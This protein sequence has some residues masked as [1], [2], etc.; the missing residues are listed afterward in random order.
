MAIQVRIGEIDNREALA[1]LAAKARRDGIRLYRDRSG[2]YFASSTS[3]PGT[4]HYLT[5]YSCDCQGFAA[6]QRCKHHAALMSALGWLQGAPEPDPGMTITCAHTDGHYSLDAEPE[7]ME[8][9]TELLVDGDVKVRIVGDTFGLSV[10]WI[11]NGRPIDDLT[12]ATPSYLDHYEAVRYWIESLD[13][14]VP[15]HVAMQDAGIFPADEFVD[16]HP[17]AA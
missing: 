13:T 17:L 7:W 5:G 16:A 10:H 1:R 4:L 12:G 3:T 8:P 15:A 14:R 9:F 11:E 6:H 2:R